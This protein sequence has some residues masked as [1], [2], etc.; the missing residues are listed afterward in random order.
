MLALKDFEKVGMDSSAL[1]AIV[2]CPS[3]LEEFRNKFYSC[4]EA[5]YHASVSES[6]VIGVLI[7]KYFFQPSEA[8]DA[9][10]QLTAELNL[11]LIF[12]KDQTLANYRGQVVLANQE[13]IKAEDNPR[14]EIGEA[15]KSIISSFLKEDIKK[16][17]TLDRAFEKTCNLLGMKVYRLP[18][19]YLK[20]VEEVRRLNKKFF[21]KKPR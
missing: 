19:E 6:E 4:K 5:F 11:N 13:L 1:I 18:E 3:N 10:N 20:R 7:N 12:W 15:D 21:I 8:R 9:W 17:Y 2:H 16:V 14:L